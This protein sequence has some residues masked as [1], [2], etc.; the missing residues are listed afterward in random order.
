MSRPRARWRDR[1]HDLVRRHY[2]FT[3]GDD[4]FMICQRRVRWQRSTEYVVDLAATGPLR[5]TREQFINL[6]QRLTAEA[7]AS[8]DEV[9]DLLESDVGDDYDD[10]D[11]FGTEEDNP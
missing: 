9:I 7:V 3:Q 11:D 6:N 4:A 8:L 2:F 10:Y 1:W 5:V